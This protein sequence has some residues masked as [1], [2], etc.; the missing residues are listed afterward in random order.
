MIASGKWIQKAAWNRWVTTM[1]REQPH[2]TPVTH[3]DIGLSEKRRGGT[4]EVR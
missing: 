2:K 1:E 3:V 4:K